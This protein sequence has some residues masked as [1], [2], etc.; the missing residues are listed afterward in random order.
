MVDNT[1]GENQSDPTL[2]RGETVGVADDD[3]YRAFGARARRRLLYLLSHEGEC[4]VNELAVM[5][6]GWDATDAGRVRD[7]DTYM[8]LRTELIHSHLPLLDDVGL[9]S[10]D[11]EEMVVAIE[12]LEPTV[13]ALLAE[14][15][16]AEPETTP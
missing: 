2:R 5:L 16:A 3:L 8:R 1:G 9:V 11:P 4:S 12:P 6:T 10:Y 14:S 7:A 13:E 15:I